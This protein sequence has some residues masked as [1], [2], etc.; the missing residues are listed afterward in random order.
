[1]ETAP[2]PRAPR[3]RTL[4]TATD[5]RRTLPLKETTSVARSSTPRVNVVPAGDRLRPAA[6]TA[7]DLEP[8]R[9]RG[10][11]LFRRVTRGAVRSGSPPPAPAAAMTTVCC[12]VAAL[13]D[14]SVAVTVTVY[15]PGAP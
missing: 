6:T 14:E 1:M 9:K 8:A 10:W 4:G 13:P 7:V 12:S 3:T 15:E 5:L 11:A 2:G